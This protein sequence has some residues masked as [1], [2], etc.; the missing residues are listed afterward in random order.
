MQYLTARNHPGASDQLPSIETELATMEPARA[1]NAAF[2]GQPTG[3]ATRGAGLFVHN[4][5]ACHGE[6]AI[7]GAGPKLAENTILKNEGAFW[8]T[9]LYGRG[10]M[11]AWGECS[12]IRRSRIFMPGLWP[13]E[14]THDESERKG[15]P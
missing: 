1:Q 8:E 6:G 10:P 14:Q 9:V 3:V 15:C 7:G 12:H 4:C 11:P 2:D 5:Q 13:V